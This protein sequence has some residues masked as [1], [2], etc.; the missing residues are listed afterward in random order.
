M[1]RVRMERVG[2]RKEKMER[3]YSTGQ[4]PHRA[5]APTEEEEEEEE[6]EEDAEQDRYRLFT[7][8]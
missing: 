5:I 8:S 4:S 6:E 1:L 2:D 3:Y 7:C